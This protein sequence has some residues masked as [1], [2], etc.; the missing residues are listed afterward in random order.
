VHRVGRFAGPLAGLEGPSHA[1]GRAA[2]EEDAGSGTGEVAAKHEA[3]SGRATRHDHPSITP[4]AGPP[5]DECTRESTVPN[6]I[7]VDDIVDPSQ[8]ITDFLGRFRPA[9][10]DLAT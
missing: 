7:L 4:H 3:E 6:A 1:V 5:A 9:L 8:V 10:V 2:D